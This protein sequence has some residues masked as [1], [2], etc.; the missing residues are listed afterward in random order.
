MKSMIAV[1]ILFV[2]ATIG[3]H[4]QNP[5]QPG[6]MPGQK[7][8]TILVLV[9]GWDDEDLTT[10]K[11]AGAAVSAECGG[12]VVSAVT[13]EN[14]LCA[15]FVPPPLPVAV[16]FRVSCM[17]YSPDEMEYEVS[18]DVF[19]IFI[20]DK[21]PPCLVVK[22]TALWQK[23]Q[24]IYVLPGARVEL[25]PKLPDGKKGE[26]IA[27]GVTDADGVIKFGSQLA[28]SGWVFVDAWGPEGYHYY[29]YNTP[30]DPIYPGNGFHLM[31][32]QHRQGLVLLKPGERKELT[33]QFILYP[34]ST[35]PP[36]PQ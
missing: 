11:L 20:L 36:Q 19:F 12:E 2:S 17:G 35:L 33:L 3:A 23:D 25:R 26:L 7:P 5:G 21:I 4:A 13:D 34:D 28:A 8:A 1:A 27:S 32:G 30:D 6:Q 22:T 24:K 14:G 16:K 18:G 15:I 31:P 10:T 29:S 9:V